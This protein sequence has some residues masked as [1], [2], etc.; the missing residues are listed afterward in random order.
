MNAQHRDR[1]FHHRGLRRSGPSLALAAA[2]PMLCSALAAQCNQSEEPFGGGSIA[3][4]IANPP[5]GAPGVMLKCEGFTNPPPT[6]WPISGPG[7]P[8]FDVETAWGV[9]GLGQPGVIDRIDIDAMSI[10]LD[11]LWADANGFVVPEANRWDALSFSVTGSTIAAGSAVISAEPPG[12]GRS[13]DQFFYVVDGSVFPPPPSAPPP[14]RR[15]KRGHDSTELGFPA[16]DTP[17]MDALDHFMPMYALDPLTVINFLSPNPS[18]FFSVSSATVPFVPTAWW[19]NPSDASGATI[20]RSTWTGTTWSCPVTFKSWSDLGLL[21][22]DDLDA[23][24][25]DSEKELILFSTKRADLA[26][27]LRI[28]DCSIDGPTTSKE[29]KCPDGTSMT[30]KKGL[31]SDDDDI[32]A[33][34]ALDPLVPLGQMGPVGMGQLNPIRAIM[35]APEGDNPPL[36]FPGVPRTLEGTGFMACPSG[37][38]PCGAGSVEYKLYGWGWPGAGPA[39]GA[40]VAFITSWGPPVSIGG[41]L[42]RPNSGVCGDPWEVSLCVPNAVRFLCPEFEIEVTWLAL[43][44]TPLTFGQSYPIV[45]RF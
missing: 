16:A 42:T 26:W 24:A 4:S 31:Q 30:S 5:V 18:Y 27:Q 7:R 25:I 44:V 33:L 17:E 40:I 36:V 2:L 11:Y 29:Y 22:T 13:A 21:Q 3:T 34:C 23:L 9:C 19:T 20:L 15:T 41:T 10:G 38:S 6:A 35:G 39:P 45:M 32:D 1:G 28:V 43:Q 12:T 14:R 8:H 37:A